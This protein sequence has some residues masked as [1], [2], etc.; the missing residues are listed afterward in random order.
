MTSSGRKIVFAM[1]GFVFGN[2]EMHTMALGEKAHS[3]RKSIALHFSGKKEFK[4]ILDI[5]RKLE[6]QESGCKMS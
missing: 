5:G 4:I 1:L 3:F 2:V 6:K